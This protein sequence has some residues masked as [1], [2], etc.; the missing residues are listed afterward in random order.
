MLATLT[1]MLGK[2]LAVIITIVLACY[3]LLLLIN[4]KDEPPSAAAQTMQQLQQAAAANTKQTAQTNGYAY[5]AK[6]GSSPNYRLAE[7][8][9]ALMR[10]CHNSD[11][12]QVLSA[13]TQLAN[14]VSEHQ[15]LT[16]FYQ[17]IRSFD[18]WYEAVPTDAAEALPSW[19]A[20]FD[21]QQLVLAQAWL[22]LQQHDIAQARQ[23]LQQDIQFWRGLLLKHNL[24]IGKMVSTAAIERHF[25]FAAM[26]QQQLDAS[27]RA[28]LTP[29]NWRIAFKQQ[30][31]SLRQVLSGEWMYGNTII[32]HTLF[33]E[34]AIAQASKGDRLGW[35]L[36][37]PLF[38]PQASRNQ[39]AAMLLAQADNAS[40]AT[41]PWYSWLYNPVGKLLNVVGAPSYQPYRQRLEQLEPLRQQLL[42]AAI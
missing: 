37:K 32:E 3:L 33:S 1:K 41:T 29:D 11:C 39:R 36:L 7:P 34:H 10:Q 21:G 15:D 2:T 4:I 12:Q 13:E 6:H 26:L 38:Q 19:Q 9:A 20:L 16:E 28:T 40:A 5:L 27:Q 42:A 35:W 24:L 23:V 25:N 31:L 17:Q 30:E 18:H 22:A 8:L 14:W